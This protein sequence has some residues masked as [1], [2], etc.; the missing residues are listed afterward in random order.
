MREL[1]I[2]PHGYIR[3]SRLHEARHTLL[4]GYPEDVTIAE[5][6]MSCGFMHMGRFSR[7][8]R[9]HFGRLPSEDR[10]LATNST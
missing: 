7:H 2:N 9:T 8:Y 5:I 10:H 4:N 6:A 3:I 1:G